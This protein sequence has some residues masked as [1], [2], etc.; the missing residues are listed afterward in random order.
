MS[1]RYA[2]IEGNEGVG[3]SSVVANLVSRVDRNKTIVIP[4][5]KM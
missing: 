2:I 5:Q 3:K 4:V 1:V